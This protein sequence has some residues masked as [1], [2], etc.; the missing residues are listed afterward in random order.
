MASAVLANSRQVAESVHRSDGVREGRIRVVPNFADDTAFVPLEACDREQ[1]RGALGVLPG[2]LVIGCVARLVPV[3]DHATLVRAFAA[4]RASRP[5]IK[6]VLV[7]DG[8]SRASIEALVREQAVS[9]S[10]VFAGARMDGLNYHQLFDVS[11]LTSRSEGFPNS[12]VEAMAAG[13]PVIATGVGGN[14]DAVRDGHTGRLV[15]AGDVGALTAALQEM[16]ESPELRIQFGANGLTRAKTEYRADR[17]FASL[18]SMYQDLV[19][20]RA[21]AV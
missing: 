8:P 5:A 11:V 3:K 16:V 9:E 1:R 19:R 10:V 15:P 14:L 2:E 21:R 4:V 17:V 13:R 6:L 18:E 20:A 12:L 7:G